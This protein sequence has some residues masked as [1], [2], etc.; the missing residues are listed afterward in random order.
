M[1]TVYVEDHVT[2]QKVVVGDMLS[3]AEASELVRTIS[4]FS[5]CTVYAMQS[6]YV[7]Y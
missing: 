5:A 4:R 3:R 7:R 2:H 1:F 6:P